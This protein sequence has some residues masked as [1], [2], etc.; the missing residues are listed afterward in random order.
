MRRET[1][2]NHRTRIP[3]LYA[4]NTVLVTSGPSGRKLPL[5]PQMM[6]HI[7]TL[8]IFLSKKERKGSAA[9]AVKRRAKYKLKIFNNNSYL[10]KAYRP[11]QGPVSRE[12]TQ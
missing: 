4:Y 5:S 8:Y 11:L 3:G 2:L 10:K 6:L 7:R 1:L 12:I 9:D